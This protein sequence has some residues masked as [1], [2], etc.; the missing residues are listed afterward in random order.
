MVGRV[1]TGQMTE[2]MNGIAGRAGPVTPLSYRRPFGNAAFQRC[3]R[4]AWR[5][6]FTLQIG[7]LL[8]GCLVAE[9]PT[10]NNPE[11]T[12]PMIDFRNTFPLVTQITTVRAF[13]VQNFSVGVR[14]EDRGDS[15]VGLLFLNY[16]LE[17]EQYLNVNDLRA[18]TFDDTDRK[19]TA[20]WSVPENL[21][22]C[23]QITMVVTHFGNLAF[24]NGVPD[25]RS[26]ADVALA[27]WWLHVNPET[28]AP[29]DLGV[30]PKS[31]S[32]Q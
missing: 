6:L 5:S 27:T 3:A 4:L 23:N 14:S 32:P 20:L 7:S 16:S 24:S 11:R 22:G 2:A 10:P 8:A 29:D 15:V 18:S 9:P 1:D 25:P 26:P 13:T 17:G 31:S 21:K 12:P 19:L 30:C 28:D